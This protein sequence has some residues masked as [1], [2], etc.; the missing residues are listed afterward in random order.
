MQMRHSLT[1]ICSVVH[2]NA[3]TSVRQSFLTGDFSD[4]QHKMSQ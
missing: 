3:E 4:F 2:N 1:A